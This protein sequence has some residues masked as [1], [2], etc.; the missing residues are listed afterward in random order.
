MFSNQT[1]YVFFEY[2]VMEIQV[3]VTPSEFPY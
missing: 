1:T 3:F 2:F